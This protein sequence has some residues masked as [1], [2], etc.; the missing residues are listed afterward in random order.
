MT[1]KEAAEKILGL[2]RDI[3]GFYS[4]DVETARKSGREDLASRYQI[5]VDTLVQV[6]DGLRN[7]I[8]SG[9]YGE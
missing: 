3:I 1:S 8:D 9:A 4:E 5:S 6:A 7:S 2:I